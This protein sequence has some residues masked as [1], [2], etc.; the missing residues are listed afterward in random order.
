MRAPLRFIDYTC[1][2]VM[3]LRGSAL[4]TMQACAAV[5]GLVAMLM[6]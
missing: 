1:T 5:E 2:T 3:S 6:A 4:A